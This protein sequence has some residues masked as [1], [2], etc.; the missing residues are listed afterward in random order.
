MVDVA[1]GVV[2]FVAGLVDGIL[3]CCGAV[4]LAGMSFAVSVLLRCIL[5]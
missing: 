4:V 5:V 1:S 2:S 3:S